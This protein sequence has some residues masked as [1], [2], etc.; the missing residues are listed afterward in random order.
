[1]ALFGLQKT[2]LIDFPHTVAATIFVPGCNLRCPYCHNPALVTHIKKDTLTHIDSIISFLKKRRNV[3]GGVCV[4]G[5][6]PLLYTHLLDL[7]EIIHSLNLKVKID[8]NGTIPEQLSKV[9]VDYIS[10]DIKTSP[11]N[12]HLVG[13]DNIPQIEKK[14][15]ASIEWIISSGIPHEF[16]TTIAPGIVFREDIEEICSLIKGADHYILSQFRPINT[17]DPKFEHF[18]PTPNK[19]LNELKEIVEK[20]GISC[21]VRSSIGSHGKIKPSEN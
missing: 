11:D 7:I 5:G 3:L 1:M 10:M 6:E 2:T 19:F 9:P 4:S 18:P 21:M 13:G 12:Y 20:S 14:V 17:L 8:T 16:R 15:K